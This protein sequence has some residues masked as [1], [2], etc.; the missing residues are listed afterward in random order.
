[1]KAQVVADGGPAD[2]RAPQ[3]RGR[4]DRATG[5]DDLRRAHHDSG[6][7]AVGTHVSALHPGR[8]PVL[9]QDPLGPA[10]DDQVSAA[11][12]GVGK[13]GLLCGQLGAG[14]VAESDVA[15]QVGIVLRRVDVSG[16]ELEV[17][18]ERLGSP[19]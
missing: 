14:D 10:V 11:P 16:D 8:A 5:D 13:V 1:M 12:V 17:P 4:L 9:H 6:R 2:P 7:G 18:A 19:P 3:Q 15:G